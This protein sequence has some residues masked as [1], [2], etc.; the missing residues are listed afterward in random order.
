M[1]ATQSCRGALR[2]TNDSQHR[3]FVVPIIYFLIIFGVLELLLL[4]FTLVLVGYD[5]NFS[6]DFNHKHIVESISDATECMNTDEI[7]QETKRT[8]VSKK[9]GI[10]FVILFVEIILFLANG[11]FKLLYY[12]ELL[13]WLAKYVHQC[14]KVLCC[15]CRAKMRLLEE[16]GELMESVFHKDAF[17]ITDEIAGL[18]YIYSET[19]SSGQRN[20]MFLKVEKGKNYP[21]T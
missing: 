1:L 15:C 20:Q 5:N 8:S 17:P 16:V 2:D 4:V 6:F 18:C 14:M 9:N 10:V 7:D 3:R 13:L 12:T 21:N 19:K 11:L